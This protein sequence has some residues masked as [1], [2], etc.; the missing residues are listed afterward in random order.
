MCIETFITTRKMDK[1]SYCLVDFFNLYI[2]TETQDKKNI[3]KIFSLKIKIF[4][5]NRN[6]VSQIRQLL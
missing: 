1:V 5:T 6:S 2:F 3:K 4:Y